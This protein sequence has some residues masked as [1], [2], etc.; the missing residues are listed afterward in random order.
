MDGR[1]KK[2]RVTYKIT[3][4]DIVDGVTH[5]KGLR[6]EIV[7]LAHAPEDAELSVRRYLEKTE[8]IPYLIN[9]ELQLFNP[10]LPADYVRIDSRSRIVEVEASIAGKTLNAADLDE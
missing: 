7:R 4:C 2:Y 1:M 3:F 8:Y 6:G 10:P 9:G 5:Q